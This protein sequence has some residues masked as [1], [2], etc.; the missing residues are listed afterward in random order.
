MYAK[1]EAC[2]SYKIKFYRRNTEFTPAKISPH[3]FIYFLVYLM[4]L[5][6]RSRFKIKVQ[7]IGIIVFKIFVSFLANIYVYIPFE[8]P[9]AFLVRYL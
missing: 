3:L 2:K 9:L 8:Q 1:D 6:L 5:F 7:G 4:I